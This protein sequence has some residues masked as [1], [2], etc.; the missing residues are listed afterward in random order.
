[1]RNP[2]RSR[3]STTAISVELVNAEDNSQIWGQQYN[4]KLADVFA[5]QEEIAKE[6]SD[7]LRL[8]LTG[9]ER[10]QLAKRPT[11]N[12]KAFQYYS[13]GRLYTNRRTREDLLAA[14]RYCEKAIE[15]DPNYALASAGLSD[16]Y[17]NLGFRGYIAPIEGRRKGEENAR[18]ALALD[19]N[20]AE[21]HVLLANAY[22]TFNPANFSLG[23]RELRRAIELSPS[24]ALAHLYWAFPFVRQGQ[25]DESLV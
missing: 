7:K 24:L 3:V 13:Q 6:I 23:D 4:R 11:E 15:E 2:R 12:L 1:M 25:F 10:Q 16:A 19:E 22:V 17:I 14:I 21:A 8:K 5:V 20:L 9:A 18:K